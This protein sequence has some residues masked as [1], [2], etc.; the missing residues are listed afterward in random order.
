MQPRKETLVASVTPFRRGGLTL[1]LEW[2]P[3]HL[4][5]LRRRGA[6]GVVPLGTNGEGPSLSVA[7]KKALIDVVLTYS[8][9]LRVIPGS[10]DSALPDTIEVSRY[11]LERGAAAVLVV[12]PF[13]FKELSAQGLWAYY[14]A[15][16]GA[17]PPEGKVLLYHIPW[18][19]GVAIGRELVDALMARYPNQ[20]LGI[21][22]SSGD[23]EQTR[24]YGERYPSLAIYT[25]SDALIAPAAQIGAAGAI[26]AVGNA[27]PELVREAQGPDT[28]V[29]A[30]AQRG[31]LAVRELLKRYP[32][33]SALKHLLHLLGDLPLTWVRP[34]LRNLTA[35]EARTLRQE[36][37]EL[38]EFLGAL[39]SSV[40]EPERTGPERS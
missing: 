13:Y 35:E 16:L 33:P 7:E 27:F 17:L 4:A 24:G 19:S 14:D 30:R 10:G 32:S 37:Q 25:G 21:K 11:A 8:E 23:L 2:L 28:T 38:R 36:A 22:D 20:L 9:G 18:L 39:D 26:S 1:D 15:L 34:P 3:Q 31:V 12:P 6:H 29:A 5:Y 40:A